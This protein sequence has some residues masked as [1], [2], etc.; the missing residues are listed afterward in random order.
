MRDAVNRRLAQWLD[1]YMAEFTR[2]LRSLQAAELDGPG[3]GL[4]FLL[5]EGL[6]NVP[7][8][9]ARALLQGLGGEDKA[10][11]GQLGVRFGVRHLYLPAM[12]KA[13]AIELRARLWAI[14]ARAD[15]QPPT[16]GR[17][18][19]PVDAK[20]PEGYGEATGFERLATWYVRI[21]IVERL[22]AKRTPA[23][24]SLAS[25][26]AGP[27]GLQSPRR[28]RRHRQEQDRAVRRRGAGDPVEP[29]VHREPSE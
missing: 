29:R 19:W 17:V 13:R 16:P 4:A 18:A 26:S 10:R 8:R 5:V 15:L 11:L 6:G 21:D 25:W 20:L 24:S 22:A 28:C 12:L 2:P 27:R 14:H 3:R 7:T 9:E 23:S 1:A